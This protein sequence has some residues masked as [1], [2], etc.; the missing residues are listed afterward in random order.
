MHVGIPRA[1]GCACRPESLDECVNRELAG[2]WHIFDSLHFVAFSCL[3][4]TISNTPTALT[5]CTA[6]S[7]CSNSERLCFLEDTNGKDI[8]ES[9]LAKN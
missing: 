6:A 7:T 1:A 3:A 8:T 5:A 9:H 2:I 4:S